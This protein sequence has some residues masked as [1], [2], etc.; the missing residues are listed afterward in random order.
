MSGQ[1]F[2][3][4][5]QTRAGRIADTLWR[6]LPSDAGLP[7]AVRRTIEEAVCNTLHA[8]SVRTL[9]YEMHVSLDDGRISGS[10]P[11][12]EYEDF[13]GLLEKESFR[14]KLLGKYPAL[15]SYL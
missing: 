15:A 11:E 2:F 9:I 12:Q 1:T 8:A 4:F 3:P 10:T 14:A 5:Y 7:L 6:E 13:C